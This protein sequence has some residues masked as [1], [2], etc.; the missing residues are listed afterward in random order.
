MGL[1]RVWRRGGVGVA[2]AESPPFEGNSEQE[3]RTC[4]K[5][6]VDELQLCTKRTWSHERFCLVL[7]CVSSKYAHAARKCAH[8]ARLATVYR[9]GKGLQVRCVHS[10]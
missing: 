10:S 8:A 5:K 7:G 6:L 9:A 3:G 1:E 2:A 4:S